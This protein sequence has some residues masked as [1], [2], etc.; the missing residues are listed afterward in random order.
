MPKLVYFFPFR[1]FPLPFSRSVPR[2]ASKT[3]KKQSYGISSQKKINI[4]VKNSVP[5]SAWLFAC[6]KNL[7]FWEILK[8][9]SS[10][11]LSF[12][13]FAHTTVCW[14]KHCLA[15]QEHPIFLW[16][17][18]FSKGL[19]KETKKIGVPVEQHDCLL[20]ERRARRRFRRVA[21]WLPLGKTFDLIDCV[22]CVKCTLRKHPEMK[23]DRGWTRTRFFPY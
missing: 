19:S 10:F 17:L 13:L 8:F 5:C 12:T 1:S 18:V 16:K 7:E 6:G 3:R 14:A 2:V 23:S 15:R 22:I 9:F 11:F 4:F 20:T 21:K